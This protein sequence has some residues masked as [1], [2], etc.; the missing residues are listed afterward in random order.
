MTATRRRELAAYAIEQH[1]LSQRHACRLLNI[2]RS[3]FRYR[4]KDRQDD[5]IATLLMDLA[6]R[7]PRWGFG[8]MFGWLRLQGHS[9]N[10]KRV[11]RVYRDCRLNLRI[12]PKK[13]FPKRDPT[14]LVQPATANHVWSVD[15]M[16]DSLESGRPFRT[17]NVL[18]EFNREALWNEVDTSLPAKRVVRVFNMI[19]SWRGYQQ[20]IR[21][22][23]G[24]EL[25]PQTMEEWPDEHE[26]LLDL[27]E[28]GKPAQNAYIE[29]FN[30]TYREEVL[31]MYAFQSLTEV[32]DIT[33]S[34]IEEYNAIR[35]HD[36]LGG[37]PPYQYAVVNDLN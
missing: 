24:P 30:R 20:A 26:V 35:P 36:A 17:F 37:L 12:K 10:H 8:K 16:S 1:G 6:E 11:R 5:D 29:R 23:N 2:S 34:W 4:A 27:I 14:L 19:A 25:I 31:D 21:S 18:D 33:E 7:K 28:P 3:V 15:F 13:R 22:D 32:R 9:W